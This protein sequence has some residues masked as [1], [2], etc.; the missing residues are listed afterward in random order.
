MKHI[1][2]QVIDR[3]LQDG[4]TNSPGMVHFRKIIPNFAPAGTVSN[5][6][7]SVA[8]RVCTDGRYIERHDGWGKVERDVDLRD[9]PNDPN[10]AIEAVLK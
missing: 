4:W 1:S 2:E 3:L 7:R 9:Y 6:A 10:G 5:G 8:L